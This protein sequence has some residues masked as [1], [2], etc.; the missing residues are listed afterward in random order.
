MTHWETSYSSSNH[1]GF[2]AFFDPKVGL[3]ATQDRQL[4]QSV[5]NMPYRFRAPGLRHPP[6]R[7]ERLR[8]D[9]ADRPGTGLPRE[10][11]G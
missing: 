4:N 5:A 9:G 1:A 7:P 2:M 10:G 3:R 11:P 8:H 6:R